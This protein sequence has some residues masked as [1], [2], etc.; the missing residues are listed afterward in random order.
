M[1]FIM[2]A[3]L[4][5]TF[6]HIDRIK[7]SSN[8]KIIWVKFLLYI[9][10]RYSETIKNKTT[11]FFRNHSFMIITVF[12]ETEREGKLWKSVRLNSENTVSVATW[13]QEHMQQVNLRHEWEWEKVCVCVSLITW[14]WAWISATHYAIDTNSS[15]TTHK[16]RHDGSLIEHAEYFQ[17]FHRL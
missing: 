8:F 10:R 9:W 2:S 1:Y 6:K 12:L 17:V 4:W 15:G 11:V 13:E 5:T 7:F 16:S 3:A 14:A